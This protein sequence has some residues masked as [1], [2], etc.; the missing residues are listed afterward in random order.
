MEELFDIRECHEYK[1]TKTGKIYSLISGKF[2]KPSNTR[3]QGVC[4]RINGLFTYRRIHRIVCETFHTNPKNKPHVNHINCIKSDNRAENLEWCSQKENV[5]HAIANN[6]FIKGKGSRKG[7][8]GINGIKVIDTETGIIYMSVSDAAVIVGKDASHLA[9]CVL[10]KR[11]NKTTI[12]L[13]T[14]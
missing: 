14:P 4:L 12:K 3:Y 7:T 1:V 5:A 8:K 6:R 11:K 9:R 2:L 13:Y 10:G